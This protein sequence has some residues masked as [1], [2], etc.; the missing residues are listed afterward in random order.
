MDKEVAACSTTRAHQSQGMGHC[1]PRKAVNVVGGD[2][3]GKKVRRLACGDSFTV[4]M[5]DHLHV[6]QRRPDRLHVQGFD[7]RLG[8]RKTPTPPCTQVCIRA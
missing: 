2:L 8:K 3:S 1:N 5:C 4:R 6:A 7:V